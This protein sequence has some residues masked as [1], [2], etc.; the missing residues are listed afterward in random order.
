MKPLANIFYRVTAL[1]GA[2]GTFF[3]FIGIFFAWILHSRLDGGVKGAF[4]DVHDNFV[5][6]ETL[7]CDV[8]ADIET[9]LATGQE[10]RRILSPSAEEETETL[11]ITP[12]LIAKAKA[13]KET[14][15]DVNKTIGESRKLLDRMEGYKKS[16]LDDIQLLDPESLDSINEK[17]LAAQEQC[18]RALDFSQTIA[19]SPVRKAEVDKE[20]S[21]EELAT[22]TRTLARLFGVL[23]RL[24]NQ[25]ASLPENIDEICDELSKTRAAVRTNVFYT[26]SLLTLFLI[27]MGS[28]Q[29][30]LFRFG[31]RNVSRLKAASAT[32]EA[33]ER[34]ELA[35]LE[36]N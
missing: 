6:V 24:E 3:C 32:A 15:G 36:P 11:E 18:E 26:S 20:K 17:F 4:D 23:S 25:F 22:V 5:N 2:T 7:A 27:W 21:S 14:L 1:L 30:T 19:S 10:L 35:E 9:A 16:L 28:G 12:G 33:D 34:D 8:Q 31:C 13:L 29:A